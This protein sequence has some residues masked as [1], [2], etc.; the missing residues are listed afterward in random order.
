MEK[1][2]VSRDYLLDCQILEG[3]LSNNYS[4]LKLAENL[5]CSLEQVQNTLSDQ[6][7]I[8]YFFG[9][10]VYQ[11]LQEHK[12][13]VKSYACLRQSMLFVLD[14]INLQIRTLLKDPN[15]TSLRLTKNQVLSLSILR[16]CYKYNGNLFLVSKQM[17]LPIDSVVA[18]L[19][20]PF[21]EEV[22]SE[23][24]YLYWQEVL[25]VSY[26][27]TFDSAKK[28]KE[29]ICYLFELFFLTQGSL[30]KMVRMTGINISILRYILS[31][32]HSM[33]LA[34]ITPIKKE[35]ILSRLKDQENLFD[36]MSKEVE[37]SI[38]LERLS[39]HDT[40]KKL[41]LSQYKIR[42]LVK[43]EI[44]LKNPVKGILLEGVLSTLDS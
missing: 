12:K 22:L 29:Q 15:D 23:Q 19:R 28:R 41:N 25:E 34:D 30:K 17:N 11:L 9:K 31:D 10:E 40:S 3:Y 27:F 33:V 24:A 21:M 35:W 2:S 1:N 26:L 16:L 18:Y 38:Y 20:A 42:K 6:H 4:Y 13:I 36:S 43:E 37:D 14:S 44:P 8:L 5:K 7:M 32:N 39:I